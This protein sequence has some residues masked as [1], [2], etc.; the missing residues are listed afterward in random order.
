MNKITFCTYPDT[1]DTNECY[2]LTN[3]T[4]STIKSILNRFDQDTVFYLLDNSVPNEWLNNVLKKVKIVFDCDKI[5]LEQ[6]RSICQK[7]Q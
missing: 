6:I 1:V 2:G 5:S 3:Y 4:N 7:K